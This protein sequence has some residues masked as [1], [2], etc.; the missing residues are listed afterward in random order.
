MMS[1]AIR[2]AILRW[3]SGLS[4]LSADLTVGIGGLDQRVGIPLVSALLLGLIGAA[5]P[6]QLTQGVGMLAILGRQSGGRP[7]LQAVLAYITGKALV[8]SALGVVAVGLGAGL[9]EV[10]IP[11]FVAARKALG[12]L[13]IVV[14]LTMVGAIRL[15]WAPG[16]TVAQRLRE[17]VRQRPGQA[18]F[19]LGVAFGFSFCPTLFALFFAF[20]IPLALSRPDGLIY[21]ALFA[22]GTALPL[23][24][25]LGLLSFGGGSMGRYARSIGRTQRVVAVLAGVLLLLVGL[26]D[27]VV[28]WLL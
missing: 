21:P 7:R 12:P 13:M 5:A 24:L 25:V 18:P 4:S 11:V 2:D 19:L 26:H 6:C 10:A 20:L 8:Y 3:Y 16:S 27:T 17:A 9:S 28:Y 22:V 23:L 14:G 1:E 15:H